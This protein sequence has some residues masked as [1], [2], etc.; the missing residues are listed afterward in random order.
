MLVESVLVFLVQHPVHEGVLV[1]ARLSS[2]LD[3]MQHLRVQTRHQVAHLGRPSPPV[4]HESL[5]DPLE[6]WPGVNRRRGAGL[7]HQ[8]PLLHEAVQ[9]GHVFVI[10]ALGADSEDCISSSAAAD[11]EELEK[12]MNATYLKTW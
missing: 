4:A 11:G 3:D 1:D 8:R 12:G 9:P 10:D 7:E 2:V 5:R 6:E